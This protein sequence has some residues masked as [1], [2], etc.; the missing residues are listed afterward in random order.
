VDPERGA[1][2]RELS[3]RPRREG[4]AVS[5]RVNR[6]A[7]GAFVLGAL[8]IAAIGVAVFFGAGWGQSKLHVLMVFDGNVAGLEVGTPIEF[9]GVRVGEIRRVRAIYDRSS[10]NARFAVYGRITGSIEVDYAKTAPREQRGWLEEM[11][12]DGLRARLET[13]SFVT[14]QQRVML[15]FAPDVPPVLTGID[16][17]IAEIPTMRSPGEELVENLR[18]IPFRDFIV[19]GRRLL[20]AA[21]RVLETADGKPGPLPTMLADVA[22]LSRTVDGEVPALSRELAQTTKSLRGA[23]TDLRRTLAETDALVG[24]TRKAIAVAQKALG[25]LDTRLDRGGAVVEDA[26]LAVQDAGRQIEALAVRVE[27]SLDRLDRTLAR[28]DHA[29]SDDAPLAAGMGEALREISGAA[30]ALRSASDLLQ[31]RPEALLRGRGE[32]R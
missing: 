1:R 8:L 22:R 16:S 26:G 25:T 18:E 11:I 13:K 30:H 17:G 31:R 9:R 32:G 24:D 2:A 10:H 5:T 23:M 12:N 3:P 29:L 15:D 28:M 20:Q 27:G 4:A 6:A 21:Q 7:I 14:G 19:D